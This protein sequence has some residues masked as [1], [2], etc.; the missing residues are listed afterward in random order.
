MKYSLIL[1]LIFYFAPLT[2][3]AQNNKS[4]IGIISILDKNIFE[5]KHVDVKTLKKNIK[6]FTSNSPD[7]SV[8]NPDTLAL[9]LYNILELDNTAVNPDTLL[10]LLE[11]VRTY[12]A[13]YELFEM[14]NSKILAIEKNLSERNSSTKEYYLGGLKRN[15]K[16][17]EDHMKHILDYNFCQYK[18]MNTSNQLIKGVYIQTDNDLFAFT[19]NDMNYTGGGRFEITTDFLKM[20]L[21][22]FANREKV[23]SYQGVFIGF[24]AYTPFIRDTSIFNT[25]TSFDVNDRPFA[26]Y[27]FIGRSKYRIHSNGHMRLRT[28][29]KVG[30]IGGDVGNIIQSII[31]RDQFVSSLK[32]YGWDSQIAKGGRFA[33]NIDHYLDLMLFSGKGDIFNLNRKKAGWLNIPIMMDAHIGNELTAF[34]AGIGL[35]N[36]SF[37]DRSGNE[38]IMMRQYNKFRIIVSANAKYRYVLHNSMLEGIG[39]FETFPNDDDPLA[40]KDVYRLNADEV[41]RHLFLGEIFIGVR[42]MKATVYWQLTINSKEYDKPK[43]KDMYQW[44]RFGVNFLF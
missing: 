30:V 37:K 34:G 33:W 22:P 23:L 5:L 42:T 17:V 9:R 29:F 3:L 32:P 21:L 6:E 25:P 18:N 44:G 28:D 10:F 7:A 36:L 15:L 40:P 16:L 39:I 1:L 8:N 13:V 41:V 43:A 11:N 19:N 14:L 35:S 38:D 27:T 26:S 20:R 31:H 2:F 12:E 4:L 24:K